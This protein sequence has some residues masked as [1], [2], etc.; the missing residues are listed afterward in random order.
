MEKKFHTF[1]KFSCERN[2]HHSKFFFPFISSSLEGQNLSLPSFSVLV[3][4]FIMQ[5]VESSDFT[6]LCLLVMS[7]A[8]CRKGG[9]AVNRVALSKLKET[10]RKSSNSHVRGKTTVAK[11]LLNITYFDL[12]DF[13][14]LAWV[15]ISYSHHKG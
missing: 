15:S 12:I 1:A 4:Q 6:F 5:H 8:F 13:K 2:S 9:S 10:E 11:A 14:N 3:I 7:E